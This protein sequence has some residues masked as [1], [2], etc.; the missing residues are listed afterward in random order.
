MQTPLKLQGKEEEGSNSERVKEPKPK[1]RDQRSCRALGTQRAA[2]RERGRQPSRETK[3]SRLRE[4][5]GTEAK[6]RQN[7]DQRGPT[8]KRGSKV[9]TGEQ[10]QAQE[11]R[12]K[13]DR[14][15]RGSKGI[16]KGAASARTKGSK[17]TD[18]EER[19]QGDHK[20]SGKRKNR[21]IS[22]GSSAESQIKGAIWTKIR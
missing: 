3:E 17:G 6:M 14:H 18:T 5:P 12:I 1:R 8:P 22:W 10:R 21:G 9:I 2:E 19:V 4:I 20:G 16:A 11:P 15:Q 7:R 13:G